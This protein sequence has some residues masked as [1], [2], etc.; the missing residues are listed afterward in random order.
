MGVTDNSVIQLECITQ[1]TISIKNQGFLFIYWSLIPIALALSFLIP[2]I[3]GRFEIEIR[4]IYMILGMILLIP[5]IIFG[6]VGWSE[7]KP[8]VLDTSIVNTEWCSPCQLCLCSSNAS[9]TSDNEEISYIDET[10]DA[11][12][13]I[14]R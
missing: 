6:I 10:C 11:V 14:K 5:S 2:G 7:L 12:V 4:N 3:F 13:L 8:D 9:L 1:D